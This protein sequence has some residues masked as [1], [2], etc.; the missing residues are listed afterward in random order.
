MIKAAIYNT[1]SEDL[2]VEIRTSAPVGITV[3]EGLG[4]LFDY[5]YNGVG[6][7]RI[8]GVPYIISKTE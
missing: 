8:R 7:G 3:D 6:N 1:M 4:L 2:N 5:H